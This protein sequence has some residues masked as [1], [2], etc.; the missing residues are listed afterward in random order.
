MDVGTKL[1]QSLELTAIDGV[2]YVT[3]IGTVTDLNIAIPSQYDGVPVTVIAGNAFR[4]C[5][6]IKSAVIP[7]GITGIG[8]GAFRDCFSLRD[9]TVDRGVKTIGYGAFDGCKSLKSVAMPDCVEFIEQYAFR[10]CKS[11][12]SVIF[13]NGI[14]SIRRLQGADRADLKRGRDLNRIRGVQP[15][16][17][18]AQNIAA[19]KPCVDT[20]LCVFLV[21][22]AFRNNLRGHARKVEIG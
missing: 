3:G 19:P 2:Y 5:R 18:T 4:G 21:R 11:L 17:G 8:Y 12:E 16:L 20:Q 6:H 9:V 7:A 13:G 22:I 14:K 1:A 15:L 10:G